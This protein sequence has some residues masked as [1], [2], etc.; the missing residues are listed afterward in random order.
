MREKKRNKI[1]IILL[2]G[3]LSIM[4]AGYAAFNTVLNIE[5]TTSINSNWDVRITSVTVGKTKGLAETEGNP[6]WKT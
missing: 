4:T 1:T 2:I 5:G 3:L 6:S